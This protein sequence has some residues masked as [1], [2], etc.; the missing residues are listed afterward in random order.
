MFFS[1]LKSRDWTVGQWV[2]NLFFSAVVLIEIPHTHL[3]LL[4]PQ[5]K[6][7][8][9][10]YIVLFFTSPISLVCLSGGTTIN[11]LRAGSSRF[12][13]QHPPFK[14]VPRGA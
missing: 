1:K 6:I 7:D 10:A 12:N 11:A 2:R 13:F 4:I 8:T 3:Q 9:G 14:D 5:G